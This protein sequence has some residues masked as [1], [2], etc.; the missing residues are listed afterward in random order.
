MK[1]CTWDKA[2]PSPYKQMGCQKWCEQAQQQNQ[3][4]KASAWPHC[5]HVL[6]FF[7]WGIPPGL[8][9]SLR[10]TLK[11]SQEAVQKG[12]SVYSVS[13][14]VL[15]RVSIGLSQSVRW[16]A[17]SLGEEMFEKCFSNTSHQPP[18]PPTSLRCVCMR[19]SCSLSHLFP[20][21]LPSPPN[22]FP[23]P[24]YWVFPPICPLLLPLWPCPRLGWHQ[25][26]LAHQGTCLELEQ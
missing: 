22:L 11:G 16:P 17:A 21:L 4:S 8:L 1:Y 2:F 3:L 19:Q 24:F 15:E 5:L 25:C 14:L 26:L 20:G 23:L 13:A 9:S 12:C 18:K 6:C 10:P 7:W